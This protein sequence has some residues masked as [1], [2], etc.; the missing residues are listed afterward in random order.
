MVNLADQGV[1]DLI[2]GIETDVWQASTGSQHAAKLVPRQRWILPDSL[3]LQAAG[4][5]ANVYRSILTA[6][7]GGEQTPTH[8]ALR[9]GRHASSLARPIENLV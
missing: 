6:V 9:T 5:E 4:L 8:I 1:Y 3:V 2:P 7:A